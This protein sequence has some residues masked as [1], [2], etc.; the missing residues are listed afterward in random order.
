[1]RE[2]VFIVLM[3]LNSG[4]VDAEWKPVEKR[5]QPMSLETLYFDPETIHREGTRA[6][7]WQLTDLK[8]NSTTRFLSFKT[9][10]E[11]NCEQSR[12]RVLQVIEFSRQM[13]TGR[14]ASG[15]IENGNWQPVEARSV[16]HAL[17]KMACGKR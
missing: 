2:L 12:V 17:W 5:Y 1:M 8:W 13:G 3:L 6:T 11:F 14:S 7:L 15:Y 4:S 10:K 16:N 9:H